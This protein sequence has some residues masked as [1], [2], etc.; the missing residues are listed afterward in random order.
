MPIPKWDSDNTIPIPK[1]QGISKKKKKKDLQ[2]PRTRRTNVKQCLMDT[3]VMMY[4]KIPPV[5]I[6]ATN[7]R[8]E[9]ESHKSLPLVE[10]SRQLR[11]VEGE[12]TVFFKDK[13]H[14]RI[15]MPKWPTL[16]PSTYGQH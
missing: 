6:A 8:K 4:R 13:S 5:Y 1:A 7:G 10:E 9:K 15:P 2:S 12:K 14:D 11:A 16:H 3:K